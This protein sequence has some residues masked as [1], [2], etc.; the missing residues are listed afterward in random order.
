MRSVN[1]IDMSASYLGQTSRIKAY[2]DKATGILVEAYTYASMSTPM[3]QT[4]EL[5][6][7][8]TETNMW[9]ANIAGIL[10][11][12][13]IYTVAVIV[14]VVIII[15]GVIVIRRRKPTPATK[16]APPPST[17]TEPTA[18]G[19]NRNNPLS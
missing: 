5:L 13:L 17:P 19:E 3:V 7:K 2:W 11:G 4:I 15:L 12:N 14:L 16:P 6:L 18:A 9:S 1:Y 8:A 10:A